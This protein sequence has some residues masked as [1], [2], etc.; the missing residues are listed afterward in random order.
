ML[1]CDVFWRGDRNHY[2]LVSIMRALATL[3]D[4][5][6]TYVYL[7]KSNIEMHY[8]DT[9]RDNMG[10]SFA[11]NIIICCGTKYDA[12]LE[13]TSCQKLFYQPVHTSRPERKLKSTARNTKFCALLACL[14]SIRPRSRRGAE[15]I[16][17]GEGRRS[18]PPRRRLN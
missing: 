9:Y 6:S 10:V 12:N 5:C 11:V 3:L 1:L 7:S 15:R 14:V 18:R 13:I 4:T 16:R 2:A 8:Y 17:Q